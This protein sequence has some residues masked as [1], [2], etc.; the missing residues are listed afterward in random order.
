M[1]RF[2]KNSLS[3]MVNRVLPFFA[4]QS[5]HSLDSK[6]PYI[7]AEYGYPI[8]PTFADYY[9]AYKRTALGRAGIMRIIERTWVENPCIKEKEDEHDET[10][11]EMELYE[12][13]D[14][15]NF[16]RMLE[17]A[18]KRGRVGRYAG[19]IYRFADGKR[20]DE[21]VDRVPG[22]V[23]GLVGLIPAWESQLTV[24]QWVTDPASPNYGLPAMYQ[25]NE[26][27]IGD[28]DNSNPGRVLQIHPD[29]VFIWAEG[30]DDGGIFGEPALEAGLNNLIDIDKIVGGGAEGFW[31][32][33][34]AP[35]KLNVD[36]EAD[37]LQMAQA[38]GTDI[39][40]LPDKV[41]ELVADF[42][43]GADKAFLS[44]G[45]TPEA[46]S[47]SL[48]SPEH[49]L[50]GAIQCYAASI[51]VPMRVLIGNQ[52]GERASTEDNKDFDATIIS[53][54]N[55]FVIP[56]IRS[57]LRYLMRVG[58]LKP[59][60]DFY[61][62]WPDL[63][64]PTTAEKLDNAKKMAEVCKTLVG[65]GE[66]AFTGE[67]IRKEAGWEPLEDMDDM[68]DEDPVDDRTDPTPQPE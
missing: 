64:A 68:I 39:D 18:D 3:Y 43:S 34:R 35:L 33:S 29:R 23:D 31:K 67:E 40:G 12:L 60:P 25:Y 7:W 47:I 20:F 65:T 37:L 63:S 55:R 66:V 49:F 2:V 30:A 58:V 4:S 13:F 28:L 42:M 9:S 53:R 32:T 17:G 5:P 27:A 48:P 56:N 10:P 21:P 24:S 38:L 62:E 1:R 54:R 15:I 50:A 8:N 19:L 22:G 41:D 16:W 6:R 59:K 57:I 46:L 51:N 36:P 44:Q 45:M 14:R 11:W 26:A 52:T 61:V